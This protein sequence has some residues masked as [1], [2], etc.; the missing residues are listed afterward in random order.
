MEN[1][2]NECCNQHG[3]CEGEHNKKKFG[4]EKG[5]GG[6]CH[7]SNVFMS[8]GSALAVT[9]SWSVNHSIGWAIVHGLFNW[10]YVA[11]YLFTNK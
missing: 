9:L 11:Y 4:W 8:V 3:C 7:C 1:Q 10:F 6:G 5:C 2:N